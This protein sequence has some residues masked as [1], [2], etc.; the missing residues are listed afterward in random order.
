MLRLYFA[1]HGQSE[2]NVLKIFSNSGWKHPLTD[3]GVAQSETLAEHLK[4][5]HITHIFSSPVMR[6]VQTSQ[7][8]SNRLGIPFKIT[9]ALREYAVGSLEDTSTDEGWA[10]KHEVEAA[11]YQKDYARRLPGGESFLDIKNRFLPF[12][13][14]VVNNPEFADARIVLLG[15]GGTY[16]VMLPEILSGLSRNIMLEQPY[17]NTDY[18]LAESV[19]AGYLRCAGWFTRD[20]N[21]SAS[22]F[23]KLDFVRY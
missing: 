22:G 23:V 1:R 20:L 5:Q 4:P 16:S 9:E 11:W 14:M 10:L 13:N 6:A 19:P 17:R 18:I 2:A 12:I 21:E 15:H 3:L 8:L 7:I